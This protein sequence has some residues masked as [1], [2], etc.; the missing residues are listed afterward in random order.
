MSNIKMIFQWK[1]VKKN[2]SPVFWKVLKTKSNNKIRIFMKKVFLY[3]AIYLFG[4]AS[5][6]DYNVKDETPAQTEN[7]AVQT[8]K[9]ITE[10][11]GPYSSITLSQ[12][13]YSIFEDGT[14]S[15][16]ELNYPDYLGGTYTDSVGNLVF[17]VKGDMETA[18]KDI[19]SRIGTAPNLK[20]RQCAYSLRS[21][22]DLV[23]ELNEQFE[24]EG[25]CEELGWTMISIAVMENRVHVYFKD[26]SDSVIAK[27]KATVS[28]SE[29]IAFGQMIIEPLNL[30]TDS[31]CAN[32]R[33]ASINVH[34]GAKI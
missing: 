5:C 13:Y 17:L 30:P 16:T 22:Y 21:L 2:V 24:N 25:L 33:A 32:S 1:Q 11:E 31:I 23:D 14:R 34:M 7:N 28:D 20:F 18:K 6:I 9:D 15:E 12:K 4:L 8:K 10:I 29:M 27:F 19:Y 3:A 26:C